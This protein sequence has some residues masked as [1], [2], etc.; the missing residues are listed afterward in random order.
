MMDI[1]GKVADPQCSGSVGIPYPDLLLFVR[2]RLRILPSTRKKIME[3][4]DF[5]WFVTS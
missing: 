4:L 2:I 3:N 5:N 1:S